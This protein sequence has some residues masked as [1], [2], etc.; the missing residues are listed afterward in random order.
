MLRMSGWYGLFVT[1]AVFVA[2]MVIAS[3]CVGGFYNGYQSCTL[4]PV[5]VANLSTGM[6]VLTWIGLTLYSG[7]IYFVADMIDVKERR[8]QRWAAKPKRKPIVNPW[9]S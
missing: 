1:F 2:L 6:L 5:W 9:L 7:V 8:A 4:V 3:T